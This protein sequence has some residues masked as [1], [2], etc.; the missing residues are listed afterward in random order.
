MNLRKLLG[1][2]RCKFHSM[3]AELWQDIHLYVLLGT[4][5][6]STARSS[7]A[8]QLIVAFRDSIDTVCFLIAIHGV[9]FSCDLV[10]TIVGGDRRASKLIPLCSIRSMLQ[11]L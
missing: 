2:D 6:R 1:P 3:A 10:S 7:R 8:W 9:L 11:L 5:A 4:W